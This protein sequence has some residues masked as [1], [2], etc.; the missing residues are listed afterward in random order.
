M[1]KNN[2]EFIID[3]ETT[4][5]SSKKEEMAKFALER[6]F[7]EYILSDNNIRRRKFLALKRFTNPNE[8]TK[9]VFQYENTRMF[10]SNKDDFQYEDDNK[11]LILLNDL[12]SKNEQDK[13]S[14]F[15][16]ELN[17]QIKLF[18]NAFNKL[19][20]DY[21][22]ACDLGDDEKKNKINSLSKKLVDEIFSKIGFLRLRLAGSYDWVRRSN[23][24]FRTNPLSK[25]TLEDL[26]FVFEGLDMES[27]KNNSYDLNVWTAVS[28][29]NDFLKISYND[30]D[31]DKNLIGEFIND[32]LNMLNG[33]KSVEERINSANKFYRAIDTCLREFSESPETNLSDDNLKEIE[34]IRNYMQKLVDEFKFADNEKKEEH[35]SR[36]IDIFKNLPRQYSRTINKDKKNSFEAN[37]KYSLVKNIDRQLEEEFGMPLNLLLKI[38]D[39][40]NYRN[41]KS[42]DYVEAKSTDYVLE[43][44][45]NAKKENL[46][47]LDKKQKMQEVSSLRSFLSENYFDYYHA[48]EMKINRLIDIFVYL[49][50][51]DLVN[52]IG[53]EKGMAKIAEFT[54]IFNDCIA[55]TNNSCIV[56]VYD[57]IKFF[58]KELEKAIDEKNY[59]SLEIICH[60]L[61]KIFELIIS[62]GKNKDAIDGAKKPLLNKIKETLKRACIDLREQLDSNLKKSKDKSNLKNEVG[63]SEI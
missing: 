10:F 13:Y 57:E 52:N 36:L 20:A 24:K 49:D 37:K 25:E 61:K 45:V 30:N 38:Q 2:I 7:S 53:L 3:D 41:S 17:E 8:Y 9:Y 31:Y 46:S 5:D 23:Y 54:K 39:I 11:H 22:N 4:D 19:A 12:L 51:N 60:R 40:E 6:L 26:N 27:L 56:N 14:H 44:L 33:E 28:F 32:F 58:N 15:E 18:A 42:Q 29:F 43:D 62:L 50:T 48:N 1:D 47:E 63:K 35:L 55:Y 21:A 16:T 59:S 34:L